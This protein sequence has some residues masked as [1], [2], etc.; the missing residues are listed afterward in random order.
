MLK[1]R[2]GTVK[3]VSPVDSARRVQEIVVEIEGTDER[4]LNYPQ[5][6]GSV[7]SGDRVLLNTTACSLSL[8]TGGRHFV[9]A[10][11]SNPAAEDETAPGHIMKLRY[12]P[13][14]L[15]VLSVEEQDSPEHETMAEFETLDG[16]PVVCC[17][18]HSQVAGVAAGIKSLLPS[19]NVTYIM[20][21]EAALPLALS[22][23]VITL[24]A[25]GLID[26]T[27]TCGQAFGG[28]VEAVNLFSAL[29]AAK[30]VQH[31]DV[32]IV[33]QGPGNAG[34]GTPLGFSGIAQGTA[35]NTAA[36]IGGQPVVVPRISFADKRERHCGV[37]H[38][39]LTVLGKV[40]LLPSIVPV[41]RL[42]DDYMQVVQSQL[43]ALICHAEHKFVFD[44]DGEPGIS[45][46]Q[47]SGVDV[48]TMG[49]KMD[50]D[51][52]FF[53]SASAGGILAGKLV[54]GKEEVNE[55]V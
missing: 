49:R 43:S 17:E 46:L 36:S 13:N 4:A 37:S 29:A 3:Y 5:L 24:C 18:L 10:N 20:T 48:R 1:R 35:A 7:S 8:G 41:P 47:N 34:T 11:L 32:A 19:A 21:D 42:Q 45:H 14:Q 23:L 31:A 53:L 33:C 30:E 9:M 52:E 51:R 15:A 38:H 6:I 40:L 25:K 16:M 22:N 50:E 27:I 28:D 55:T 54:L 39:T 12:T 44:I 2:V 26:S